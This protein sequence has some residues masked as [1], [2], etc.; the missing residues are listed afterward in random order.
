MAEE[1]YDN[2]AKKYKIPQEMARAASADAL[3]TLE[4]LWLLREHVLPATKKESD[5]DVFS[6]SAGAI[7]YAAATHERVRRYMADRQMTRDASIRAARFVKDISDFNKLTLAGMND[8]SIRVHGT[9]VRHDWFAWL[10][11]TYIDSSAK[12]KLGRPLIWLYEP[13]APWD[14]YFVPGASRSYD[15]IDWIGQYTNP[16]WYGTESESTRRAEAVKAASDFTPA[17]KRW[18]ELT[19]A[20]AEQVTPARKIKDLLDFIQHYW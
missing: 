9:I 3:H 2:L 11:T 6:E 7:T 8:P 16:L 12:D 1:V 5:L 10:Q 18:R 14:Q 20:P 4:T 15:N 13:Q 17:E 19:G